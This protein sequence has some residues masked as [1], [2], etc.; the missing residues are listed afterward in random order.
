MLKTIKSIWDKLTYQIE[1]VSQLF[2][3]FV[4]AWTYGIMEAKY[5]PTDTWGVAQLEIF[6]RFSYYHIGLV[7]I[8]AVTSFSLALSHIQ[9]M[10]ENKN[11]YMLLMGVAALFL[12]LMLEDISW[13][14]TR[15]VPIK[16]DE[17]TMIKPYW[18]I[19]FF[20]LTYIPYWYLAVSAIVISLY[21]I[22]NRIAN[23]SYFSYQ[24]AAL[25]R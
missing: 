19:N 22:A 17:W 15:G 16:F 7:V 23:K 25:E 20:N 12:A 5:I 3:V 13:F 24:R 9:W 6:G 4:I 11:L 18:G 2:C 8:M 21:W 14:A 10:I 1:L